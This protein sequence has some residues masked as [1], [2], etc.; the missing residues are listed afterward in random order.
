M[1]ARW[2]NYFAEPLLG[3]PGGFY[4]CCPSCPSSVSILSARVRR[5]FIRDLGLITASHSSH[6]SH[7]SH[8]PEMAG[9][10]SPAGRLQ[11]GSNQQ[12]RVEHTHLLVQMM[13]F[14]KLAAPMFLLV[15]GLTRGLGKRYHINI[16]F[17]PR[18]RTVV[19][20]LHLQVAAVVIIELPHS[21][22]NASQHATSAAFQ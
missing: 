6:S 7:S 1:W 16:H 15:Y 11:P 10:M 20:N 12:L 8:R 3:A 2:G 13:C 22:D 5:H 14:R 17:L 4:F 21:F 18:T 19:Q 9:V